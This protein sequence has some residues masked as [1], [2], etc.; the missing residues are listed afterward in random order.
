[1]ET[2][3][4]PIFVFLLCKKSDFFSLL[5]YLALCGMSW[6][7]SNCL[8]FSQRYSQNKMKMLFAKLTNQMTIPLSGRW[9]RLSLV[10]RL[11]SKS[12]ADGQCTV[13]EIVYLS[14]I[15]RK[16]DNTIMTPITHG[17]RTPST[18]VWLPPSKAPHHFLRCLSHLSVL[19]EACQR[20][21]LSLHGLSSPVDLSK[22]IRH[23]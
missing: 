11:S 22:V 12:H 4:N 3:C 10:S 15:S 20:V 14:E 21:C 17:K 2:I 23:W 18:P 7:R 6:H 13:C 5:L 9:V 1:M 19:M 16:M 8:I